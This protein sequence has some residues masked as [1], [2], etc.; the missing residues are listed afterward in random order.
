MSKKK[1]FAPVIFLDPP[2]PPPFDPGDD[3]DGTD[4]GGVDPH[5]GLVSNP[6]SYADWAKS[7]G[8][9]AGSGSF[10]AYGQ[11]WADNGFSMDAWN[12]FNPNASFTWGPEDD[13]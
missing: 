8:P 9:D 13:L 10:E 7:L 5:N 4:H 11:W 6:V 2:T 12:E 1:M 3:G